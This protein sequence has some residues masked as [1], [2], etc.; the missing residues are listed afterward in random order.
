MTYRLKPHRFTTSPEVLVIVVAPAGTP[1]D[2]CGVPHASPQGAATLLT[3]L[4]AEIERG[5]AAGEYRG[6]D[7]IA[8]YERIQEAAALRDQ[9]RRENVRFYYGVVRD[10]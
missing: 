6:A 5:L 8:A 2:G 4:E 10:F 7:L 9:R 1:T 3:K